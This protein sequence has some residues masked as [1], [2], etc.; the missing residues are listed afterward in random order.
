[1]FFQ[2]IAENAQFAGLFMTKTMIGQK[3]AKNVQSAVKY[4][5][6]ITIGFTIAKNVQ[7]AIKANPI[8]II[9]LTEFVTF[10]DKAL[11]P[12]TGMGNIT[13]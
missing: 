10:A 4:V 3:I 13:N 7:N 8:N 12:T 11:L 9:L 5:I 1:M 2:K 6:I